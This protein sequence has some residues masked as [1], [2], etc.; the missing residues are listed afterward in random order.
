MVVNSCVVIVYF[1]VAPHPGDDETRRRGGFLGFL[2]SFT[3][4]T[5]STD[6]GLMSLPSL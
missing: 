4:Q 3:F 5:T 1:M 6:W 2:P